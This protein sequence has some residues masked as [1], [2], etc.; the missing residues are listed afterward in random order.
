MLH[1]CIQF[2][3]VNLMLCFFSCNFLICTFKQEKNLND[4]GIA[5]F[6]YPQ[7]ITFCYP[8]NIQ[9]FLQA[10][11]NVLSVSFFYLILYYIQIQTMFCLNHLNFEPLRTDN[12][13]KSQVVTFLC[14]LVDVKVSLQGHG[15][16]WLLSWP[17]YLAL[18][19]SV[20]F[21]S[22]FLFGIL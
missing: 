1:R 9:V 18:A 20:N 3:F 21:L 7:P 10:D 14:L 11:M 16:N 8:H 17:F 2:N 12:V 5:L 13:Q 22:F 15:W 6:C 4:T 19:I